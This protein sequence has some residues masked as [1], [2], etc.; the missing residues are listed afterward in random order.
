M[1]GATIDI[2]RLLKCSIEW[3]QKVQDEMICD[4]SECTTR[5][6]NRAARSADAVLK[7]NARVENDRTRI[8][9]GIEAKFQIRAAR[10]NQCA[11]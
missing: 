6:F 11:S 4:F 1:N 3:A 10:R 9:D 8:H 7:I 5:E 2:A